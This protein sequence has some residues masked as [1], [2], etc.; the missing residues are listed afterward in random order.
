MSLN[1]QFDFTHGIHML[2]NPPYSLD[3]ALCCF[4]QLNK[5]G[6]QRKKLEGSD[7]RINIVY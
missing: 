5:I 6:L 7:L 4:V 1:I 3:Y 2:S